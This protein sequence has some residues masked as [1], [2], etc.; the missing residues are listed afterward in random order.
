[1]PTFT[2]RLTCPIYVTA[3]TEIP[4][5]ADT[6]DE[7]LDAACD[8]LKILDKQYTEAMRDY[9]AGRR[10][11]WPETVICWSVETDDIENAINEADIEADSVIK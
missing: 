1:M 6:E 3:S 8:Q 11:D 9:T 10:K 5:V 2:V 4:V 7:A